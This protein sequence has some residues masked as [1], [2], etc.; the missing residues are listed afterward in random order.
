MRLA[1]DTETT[2]LVR[3]DLPNS[4]PSQPHLI[5][6]AA[7]LFSPKWEVKGSLKV[8]IKPDGWSI[9]PAAAEIHGITE[10][11]CARYG[12]PLGAA[13]LL[14]KSLADQASEVGAFNL[15]SFDRNV[16]GTACYRAGGV[17]LWWTQAARKMECIMEA[18]APV[19]EL[20][21]EFGGF[22]HPSLTEA[23]LR[24]VGLP[25]EGRHDAEED[26]DAAARV[27]R[28]LKDGNYGCE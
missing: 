19:C 14:F 10:A 2:G 11:A 7:K 23:H 6:L 12:V 1:F 24:L 21:G 8:L 25:Y 4:D 3:K 9:E 13:L 27:W 28:A 17:G 16:I 18:S 5:Q 26:L 15:H 20:P 22:K